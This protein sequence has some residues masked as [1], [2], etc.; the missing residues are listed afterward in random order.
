MKNLARTTL[1]SAL[2]TTDI[3]ATLAVHAQLRKRAAAGN[4]LCN[5][6]F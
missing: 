5:H 3:H 4:P 1:P 6:R 2:I